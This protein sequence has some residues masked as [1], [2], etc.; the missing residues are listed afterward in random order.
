MRSIF[1]FLL[2]IPY[3]ANCIGNEDYT[4]YHKQIIK[5]EKEIFL[6]NRP[7]TGLHIFKD[8]FTSYDFAFVDDCIEAFQIALVFKRNDYAMLFIKKAI[9]NGFEI[10]LLDLL[11]TGCP[12]N[13]YSDKH[14]VAIYEN[15]LQ[16]N[17]TELDAYSKRALF[18]FMG[19]VDT[20]LLTESLR[21]MIRDEL[22]KNSHQ[23][24]STSMKEQST[25]YKKILKDNLDYIA[26]LTAKG[27]Y[28]GERNLGI[29]TN[30]LGASA[31]NTTQCK[32]DQL[33]HYGLP[34][35]TVVPIV[36]EED[37]FDNGQIFTMLYHNSESYNTLLKYRDDAVKKGYWHPREFAILKKHD[38][39]GRKT[40]LLQPKDTIITNST[41]INKEREK[42]LIAPFELDAAK[43]AFAHKH[44]LQLFFGF[45]NGGR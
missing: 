40:M 9:D 2:F 45:F 15:F 21:R 8:V 22:F 11:S 30:R 16:K 5:A 1:I 23:N 26:S 13:F 31:I 25:E 33:K 24:L 14:K 38:G 7:D 4:L 17:K 12:C 29:Y 10:K 19:R 34:L 27:I 42:Q 43:H 32:N 44:T 18:K 36:R 28:L 41:F 20:A 6:N 39:E 35:S 37:Y 3:L